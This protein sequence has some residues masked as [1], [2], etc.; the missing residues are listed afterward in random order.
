MVKNGDILGVVYGYQLALLALQPLRDNFYRT[1]FATVREVGE[2]LSFETIPLVRLSDSFQTVLA[3]IIEKR[4][5]DALII[6]DKGKPVGLLTL[7]EIMRALRRSIHSTGIPVRA[8]ASP[9]IT[10]QENSTLRDTLI[11]MI[12]KRA[13]RAVIK[14]DDKYHEISEREVLK[15]MFSMQ[16]LQTIR[17]DPAGCLDVRLEE[18]MTELWRELP[19]VE[20]SVDVADGWRRASVGILGALIV[21]H[22]KIA[23]PWDLVVKPYLEGGLVL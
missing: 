9:L 4:F 1:L 21:D 5:G 15:Y 16:G 14:R 12:K 17:D 7:T 2:S 19:E 18:C 20:G 13:R 11:F 6:D 23:T 10:I 8:V 22:E 3:K